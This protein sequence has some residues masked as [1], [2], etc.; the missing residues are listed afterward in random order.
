MRT[1]TLFAA[2]AWSAA[3][4]AGTAMQPAERASDDS[5]LL[6]ELPKAKHSLL[7]G[8]HQASKAPET[9]ISA[10]FELED[11][12]E[13]SLSV[14]TAGK[15]LGVDAEHNVLKELA[16]D[17]TA[18]KWSPEVEVFKDVEHVSR[19]AE[20][21]T[22]MSLSRL[23]LEDIIAKAAKDQPG[24]VYSVT[25]GVRNRKAVF[26]VLVAAKDRPVELVYD[27][28]TGEAVKGGR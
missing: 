19:A 3:A 16:G 17:P 1:T 26:T 8:I 24:T 25:P 15:G 14:Y 5:R 12:G 2:I 22:V 10:K 9:A 21:L 20:Q 23:S 4:L 27:A 11:K 6:Q 13:L 28:M 7:D 18:E